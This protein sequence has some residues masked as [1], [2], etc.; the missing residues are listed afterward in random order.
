MSIMTQNQIDLLHTQLKAIDKSLTPELV[1]DIAVHFAN[2][3]IL[4][5]YDP[6]VGLRLAY[7]AVMG[8]RATLDAVWDV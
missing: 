7:H 6:V 2:L 5:G 4:N 1:N 8:S 3:V